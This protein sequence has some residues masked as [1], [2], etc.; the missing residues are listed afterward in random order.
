M[1]FFYP[2]QKLSHLQIALYSFRYLR[3]VAYGSRWLIK[4]MCGLLGWEN[5]RPLP[6]CVYNFIRK[7]YASADTTGYIPAEQRS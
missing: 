3:A 7:T 5:T 6:V 1:K 2:W 4:W